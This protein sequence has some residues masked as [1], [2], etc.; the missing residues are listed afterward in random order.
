VDLKISNL[1]T[2]LSTLASNSK[3]DKGPIKY[4]QEIKDASLKRHCLMSI[5]TTVV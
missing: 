5:P 2:K 3:N 1:P 4:P